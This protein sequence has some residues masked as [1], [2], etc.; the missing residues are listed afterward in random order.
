MSEVT[1]L[2]KSGSL[3]MQA[4]RDELGLLQNNHSLMFITHDVQL[5]DE[6]VL[7]VADLSITLPP[8]T[9]DLLRRAIRRF[10][11]QTA[12]GVT[13]AMAKL[14]LEVIIA[15]MR[16]G[17]SAGDC[18][19]NLKRA[20]ERGATI[21]APDVPHL[22]QLPLTGVVERWSGQVLR[23][24]AVVETDEL[25]PHHIPFVILE[26]PP[27]TGKTL[28]ANSLAATA[29]W[30]FVSS[31]VGGWFTTGDGALGGVARNLKTFVDQI[32]A[33]EPCIGF[34]DELDA[35]PDRQTMD[36]RGR[37]WWTPIITLFLTEIDRLRN[38]GRK[39]LLIGATNYYARLDSAL[40]RPGR[41]Q[42][43]VSVLPPS[44]DSELLSVFRY[45]L[46]SDLREA[47]L[48]KLLNPARGATPASI[49][50]WVKDARAEARN[51]GRPLELDDILSQILP[52]DDR[53]PADIRAIA[54]HELGHAVVA[55]RLG[56]DVDLISIVPNGAVDG[57]VRS[58][59]PTTVFT[60]QDIEDLVTISLGGRAADMV[61][62]K[63][64][65]AG[66]E[67]D[68]ARATELLVAA[69]ENQGLGET[70]VS[71]RVIRCAVDSED[72]I[73][74]VENDLKR[75]LTKAM[76]IV[77]QDCQ[78]IAA[79]VD[80]LI[81]ARIMSGTEMRGHLDRSYRKEKTIRDSWAED[82]TS[83]PGASDPP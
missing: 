24:L 82:R 9:P 50:G 69:K 72:S 26:G 30:N 45:W 66:A 53:P 31:S 27:G 58:T 68:L 56:H 1:E 42:K 43:R 41:L 28:I 67:A 37:D 60:H 7:A 62:S 77:S 10:T 73:S 59:A 25:A 29:G 23:D 83:G 2:K 36:P 3:R 16:P 47:N 18:V 38:S 33:S 21:A 40:V 6:A 5:L 4:G 75:L 14:K 57:V 54:V 22:D 81:D 51:H 80:R 65:N 13:P 8:L 76:N 35:L 46:G 79:L 63:G 32:L 74:S 44:T 71:R 52:V 70:L 34:L 55:H 17:A 64:P 20:V 39:I 15:S 12:R 19:A 11:G 49:E 48:E 78:T 61:L